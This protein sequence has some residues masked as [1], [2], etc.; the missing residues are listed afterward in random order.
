MAQT[1]Q[2]L[3][4]IAGQYAVD[5]ARPM[6]GWGA[7]LKCFVARDAKTGREDAMALMVRRDAPPNQF[8]RRHH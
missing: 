7:G 6:Q 5:L 3:R 4:L 1:P 2:E 8:R